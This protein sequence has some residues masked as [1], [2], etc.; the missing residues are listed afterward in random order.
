MTARRLA[1]AALILALAAA[2]AVQSVRL[3]SLRARFELVDEQR[4]E[5][6]NLTTDDGMIVEPAR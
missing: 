2:L 1:L 5:C 4:E 6:W 3:S